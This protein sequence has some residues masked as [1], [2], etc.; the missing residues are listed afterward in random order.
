MATTSSRPRLAAASRTVTGKHVARL[1]RAG[2]LPGVV[3][4]H[5]VE[6]RNVSLDAHEFDVFRKRSGPNT[7]FDLAIDSDRPAPALVH[8]VQVHPLTRR[9]VHVDLL[10]VRMTEEITVEVPIVTVGVSPAVDRDSG[11]LSH[12]TNSIRVRALPDHLPQSVEVSVES[13][14]SFDAVVQVRDLR[15][16]SDVTVL[17]DP[18]EVVA[19]VLPPRI[20][21]EP[22]VE[23]PAEA[24]AVPAEGET[25][26]TAEA[27]AGEGSEAAE[28]STAS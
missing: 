14:D 11:T 7:L 19:R 10:A 8:G 20:E 4:G 22:V 25:A 28:G 5:G 2:Q 12:V 9:P 24:E 27:G 18:D 21:V 3:Y 23:A 17:N 6:S 13:L 1:R 15:V 26:G 16:P